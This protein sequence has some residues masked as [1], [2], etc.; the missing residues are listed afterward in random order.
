L[1]G[2]HVEHFQFEFALLRIQGGLRDP[3]T[4]LVDD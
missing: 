1:K 3:R 4:A 2:Y